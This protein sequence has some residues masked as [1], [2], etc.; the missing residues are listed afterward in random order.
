MKHVYIWLIR[1]REWFLSNYNHDYT[2]E[3]IILWNTITYKL[4]E[5]KIW[6][7]NESLDYFFSIEEVENHLET[8]FKENFFEVMES[9]ERQASGWSNHLETSSRKMIR[10]VMRHRLRSSSTSVQVVLTRTRSLASTRLVTNS[11]ER[12]GYPVLIFHPAIPFTFGRIIISPRR[13]A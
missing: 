5:M 13:H 8:S 4:R 7:K 11:W 10:E 12:H 3:L 9:N 6:N 1:Q 2:I